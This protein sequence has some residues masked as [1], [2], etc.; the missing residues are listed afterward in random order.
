[1]PELT[2]EEMAALAIDLQ[3]EFDRF[4]VEATQAIAL[5]RLLWIARTYQLELER[6]AASLPILPRSGSVPLRGKAEFDAVLRTEL[7]GI[8]AKP[9]PMTAEAL[10]ERE[11]RIERSYQSCRGIALTDLTERQAAAKGTRTSRLLC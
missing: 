2:T 10:A 3:R 7:D 5:R 1:M 11:G 8:I 4:A 6:L 9:A